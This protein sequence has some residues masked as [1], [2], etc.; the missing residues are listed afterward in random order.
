MNEQ[1]KEN[2]IEKVYE[3]MEKNELTSEEKQFVLD[4]LNSIE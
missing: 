3:V 1:E 4:E 2:K